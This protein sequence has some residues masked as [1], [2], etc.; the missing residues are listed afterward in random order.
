[1]LTFHNSLSRFHRRWSFGRVLFALMVLVVLFVLGMLLHGWA[2]YKLA[3]SPQIRERLNVMLA[4]LLGVVALIWMYRIFKTPREKIAAMID[5]QHADPRRRVIAAASMEK[6]TAETPMQQFHLDRSLNDAAD[7]LENIPLGGQM[8]FKAMGKA[9]CGLLLVAAIVGGLNFWAAEPFQVTAA[10]VFDPGSD[11]PPYS[12]L[13]FDVTPSKLNAL[14]GGEAVAQVFITGGEITSDVICLIRNKETGKVE[15][16]TAYQES[17][18][19]YARKFTNTLSSVEFAFATGRARSSWHSL[20]VLLQ[21]KVSGAMVTVQPPTYTGRAKE[22]FPLES[23]E[24]KALEG[25]TI[26]LEVESNRP[27]SGGILSVKPLND[28][29]DV[30]PKEVQSDRVSGHSVQFTWVAHASSQISATIKDIRSTPSEKPLR[31]KLKVTPDQVPVVDLSS[32]ELMVLATPRTELPFVALVEDDHGLAKVSMVRSLLGYRD[33]SR[34][35]ADALVKRDF[36]FK[37][38][39]KLDEIGVE[40]GQILEFYLEAMD[41]NPSLLGQGVSDVVRVKIISE[42]DYAE[43]LRSKVQL[44]EFTARYRALS[45]AIKEAKKALD[46]L[47]ASADVGDEKSFNEE[48]KKAQ[49]AHEKAKQLA[50]KMAKDFKA[51]AMEDRLADAAKDAAGKLGQNKQG[52]GKLNL[53]DGESSTRRAI[54]E[55]KNRL[56]GVQKKAEQVQVDA[57]IVRKVGRVMEMAAEFKK[58]HRAQKS[59]VE[60]I[61]TIAKEVSKGNTTNTAQLANLGRQQEHNRKAL[62]D[63][64]VELKKRSAALPPGFEQMQA[65]TQEFLDALEQ[66]DIPE[67]MQAAADFAK[68]G[69]SVDAAT[70]AMLVL[71]LMDQLINKPNNGF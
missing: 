60:R 55:M 1:M 27:L 22:T 7:E 48:I 25:S 59:L 15:Q 35:L 13:V 33:R 44:R 30:L 52:L 21:P 28:N 8:P 54:A 23:G 69:K 61:G 29:G 64:A 39:L 17:P 20:D 24:I 47:D 5:D 36:N 66:L 11:I 34:T 38:P 32:P 67:P 68:K 37:E 12:P 45:D 58:I 63:L 26:T 40:V 6:L 71:S 51:F 57:E 53:S 10:R 49:S 43:R 46:A 65:D 18:G 2:D 3:L 50:E 70:N 62:M 19:H 42:E 9:V 4:V 31:V 16:T 56:G 41:R 14:Y